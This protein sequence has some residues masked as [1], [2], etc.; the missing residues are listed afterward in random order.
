MA[1]DKPCKG[2]IAGCA[3]LTGLDF[4]VPTQGFGRFAT[5]ALGFA[6]SRFQRSAR[7]P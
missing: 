6:A 5:F 2:G 4:F 7:A 3:V 1:F